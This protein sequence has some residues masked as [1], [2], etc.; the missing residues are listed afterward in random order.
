MY[1][2]VN[3]ET[4]AIDR[5]LSDV[6]ADVTTKPPFRWLPVIAAV[7]PVATSAQVVIGPDY[8]VTPTGVSERY[9]VRDKTPEELAT[10]VDAKI[11]RINEETRTVLANFE[12]RLTALEGKSSGGL[13][14]FLRG[15]FS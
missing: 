2:L 8:D 13:M 5:F 10:D 15:L 9:T 11:D 7:R 3:M 14:A 1:A 6:A 12:G 4:M